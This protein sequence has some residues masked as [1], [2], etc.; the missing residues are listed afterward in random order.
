MSR[1]NQMLGFVVVFAMIGCHPVW[2]AST[3]AELNEIKEEVKSLKEGQA[4]MQKELSDIK[5]LLEEGARAAPSQAGFKATDITIGDAPYM[6]DASATVTLME[7]SDYD[8]PFCRRHATQVMPELVKNYV[9]TGKLKY[10]MRENPL[11]MHPNAM[12]AA[13]AALCAGE[14]GQYWQMHD[15]LFANQRQLAVENLK[16]FG[17]E[18]GLDSAAFDA[19]LDSGNY[20]KRVNDDIAAGR[21][22]GVR[23]TPGFVIGLTDPDDP[24]KAHVTEFINGAQSLDTFNRTIEAL[25]KKAE[26]G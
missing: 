2:A 15:K 23:G 12:G 24:N 16:V 6:G 19:C 21:S 4:A 22:L 18:L 25:L 5:K 7:F 14:Q 3:K 10:V 1:F 17:T 26:E 13:Q 20:E 11:A 8:C 9:D